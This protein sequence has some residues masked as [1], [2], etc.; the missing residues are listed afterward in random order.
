MYGPHTPLLMYA[1]DAAEARGAAVEHVWWSRPEQAQSLDGPDRGPWVLAEVTPV[2]ERQDGDQNGPGP[3]P[4]LIGKSLGVFA[5]PL[6]ADRRLPA[7]WFTPDLTS[8]WLVESLRRATAPF[9]L[10]GGTRDRRWDGAL[11]RELSDHVFEVCDAD[12]GMTVPG[13]LAGSAA[14]LGKVV[15]A[16]EAFLDS[17]VWAEL[18]APTSA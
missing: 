12:H 13:P 14:V 2:L 1:A 10:V 11:A 18:R 4:L 6:A 8:S 15:T 5:A 16:V 3:R 7:I 17:S 9:L